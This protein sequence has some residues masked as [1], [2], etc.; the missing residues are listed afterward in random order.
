MQVEVN[1]TEELLQEIS[2][3]I[4]SIAESGSR[5]LPWIKNP[6]DRDLIFYTKCP[7]SARDKAKFRQIRDRQRPGAECW[8][9]ED[10][11]DIIYLFSYQ[12]KFLKP[13][14]GQE[15]P[16]WD[17]FDPTLEEKIKRYL[18]HWSTLHNSISYKLWYHVLTLIYLYQNRDYY[19]TEEQQTKVQECHDR[20]MNLETYQFIISQINI[21][22]DEFGVPKIRTDR[23]LV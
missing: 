19:L 18:I 1:L 14:W 17:I 12:Y 20:K 22:A 21:W 13:I 6:K 4:V 7:N 8:I 15:F 9:V 23:I 2:P 11:N 5:T 16:D 3:W 10:L